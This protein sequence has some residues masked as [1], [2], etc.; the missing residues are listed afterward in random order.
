MC[1]T[2]IHYSKYS[3]IENYGAIDYGE[4][5]SVT[6]FSQYKYNLRLIKNSLCEITVHSLAS[7][8]PVLFTVKLQGFF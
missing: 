2:I 8:L 3:V 6:A 7:Q 1:S 5:K 4:K